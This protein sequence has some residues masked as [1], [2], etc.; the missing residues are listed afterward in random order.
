MSSTVYFPG[1]TSREHEIR[2]PLDRSNPAAGEITVFARELFTD[3]SLPP[4]I[5]FQ[6]GPGKPGPRTV[7]EWMPEA[8]RRYRIVLLDE[9]GTGRSTKVDKTTPERITPQ[10]LSHL[11]PP[12]VAA[13]AE[14]LREH[15]GIEQWDLLGNSFGAACAGSYL[16]YFPHG[17]RRAHLVGAVPEPEMDVDVF[18]RAGYRLLAE[19]QRELFAEVAWLRSR[20]E[21]VARHVD[22]HD[23][24]MPTGERLSST[25]LRSSGVLLGEEGDFGALVNLFEAPFTSHRGEL[26][27]RGDFL[28]Q[29]GGIISTETMPLWAV[30]HETV[31]AR[32]GHPVNWSAERIYRGEFADLTLLGNQF[33]TTHFEEDPALRPFFGAV[34]EVH[35]M[36]TLKAQSDDVSGNRVPAAA[37]LFTNDVYLPYELS[38]QSAAKVGNLQVWTHEQWLHDAIWVHGDAVAKGIFGMLE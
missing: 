10:F 9:R 14:A 33:F 5:Y 17:V 37:L 25:R 8:L 2:V 22:T 7:M 29:L 3:E 24:R 35:R 21:E 31:M 28:A 27:L 32:P 19:R 13:D 23:E 15:L 6:G 18:N 26:R 36:D 38:I 20:V 16:S 30:V 1:V 12:D 34:D 11:R 4:L